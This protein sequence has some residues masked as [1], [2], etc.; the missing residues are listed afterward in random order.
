[1][2]KNLINILIA[3]DSEIIRSGLIAFLLE[4]KGINIIGEAVNGEDAIH[5]VNSLN[6]DIVVLD[7]QMPIKNGLEV[8]KVIKENHPQII[9]LVLTNLSNRK[10]RDKCKNLGCDLFLDKSTQ[11]NEIINAIA[12]ISRIV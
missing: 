5:K 12:L 3:D 2:N 1:M 11:F 10:Y 7:I 4:M 8:L 6:P 9:V